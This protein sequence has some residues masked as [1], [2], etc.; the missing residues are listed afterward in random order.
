MDF[1][2]FSLVA[3]GCIYQFTLIAME[4][5]IPARPRYVSAPVSNM[6]AQIS[7]AIEAGDAQKLRELINPNNIFEIN[8][9]GLTPMGEVL[10]A[11]QYWVGG[12]PLSEATREEWLRELPRE[13]ERFQAYKRTRLTND[14]VAAML[15]ILAENGGNLDILDLKDR[16]FRAYLRRMLI[17]DAEVD[18]L[19]KATG[20]PR[21]TMEIHHSR[22]NLDRAIGLLEDLSREI[23]SFESDSNLETFNKFVNLALWTL[24]AALEE[25]RLEK[26]VNLIQ[27][28]CGFLVSAIKIERVGTY[29]IGRVNYL[30]DIARETAIGDRELLIE[31]AAANKAEEQVHEAAVLPEPPAAKPF[32]M[33]RPQPAQERRKLFIAHIKNDTSRIVELTMNREERSTSRSIG[34]GDTPIAEFIDGAGIGIGND[35]WYIYVTRDGLY[36]YEQR[37]PKGQRIQ[38]AGTLI[39]NIIIT[40]AGMTVKP[41]E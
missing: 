21:V 6:R 20:E 2:S 13:A 18:Q 23:H 39:A 15:R 36:T 24:Q 14:Q 4:R 9:N 7:A 27:L 35:M 5:E 12:R 22:I 1:K 32:E 29:L 37:S 31:E 28:G 30:Y 40:D 3:L 8:P 33:E 34:L 17:T 38:F 10:K 19:I 41:V 26:A 11:H 16:D 25:S